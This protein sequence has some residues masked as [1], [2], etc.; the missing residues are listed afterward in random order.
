MKP[1]SL[2]LLPA[3]L[4]AASFVVAA[5]APPA[6]K[7]GLWEIRT[8]SATDG[9]KMPMPVTVQMCIDQSRDDMNADPR[10]NEDVRRRC[11]KL[12][13][14]RR[15]N[16]VVIDSVCTHEGRTATSH[17]VISGN[18][19]TD[20]RMENT[21]RFSP[22]MNGM[23]TMSSTMTGKWIGPCKPGQTHGAT[24]VT[25]VP[26]M[27]GGEFQIDP[28]MMKRMQQMQQQHGR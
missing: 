12:E 16:Q 21:T 3:A 8:E 24:S 7:S 19:A 17:T 26:G 13:T 18:L 25:G 20:Y 10:A 1:L 22:P 9:Q 15:G 2:S 5:D 6:R 23:Q 4:L 14:S 28:E 11:S 27:P